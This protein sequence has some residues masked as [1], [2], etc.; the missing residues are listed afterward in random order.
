MGRVKGF[1]FSERKSEILVIGKHSRPT[2]PIKTVPAT[3]GDWSVV[4]NFLV[5][6]RHSGQSAEER[7]LSNLLKILKG[8]RKS[9]NDQDLGD[10]ITGGTNN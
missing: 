3:T 9:A 6:T 1:G 4:A 10:H 5:W 2:R 8:S 7:A